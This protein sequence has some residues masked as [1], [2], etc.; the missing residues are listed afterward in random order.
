MLSKF[1]SQLLVTALI[2]SLLGNQGLFAVH[3]HSGT[4]GAEATEHASRP[5]VHV[6]SAHKHSHGGSWHSHA[7][8]AEKR[9][10][11]SVVKQSA[12]TVDARCDHDADAFYVGSGGATDRSTARSASGRAKEKFAIYCS[13]SAH[14]L[15][16]DVASDQQE[17][18]P[19]PEI[20]RSP[21]ALYL[22]H[23]SIRC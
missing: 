2:A 11:G 22:L 12:S 18:R 21:C 7:P 4:P 14:R 19:P 1:P 13:G 10:S 8:S 16:S 6:G 3:V 20:R 5:H 9:A 17:C 15:L 23:L